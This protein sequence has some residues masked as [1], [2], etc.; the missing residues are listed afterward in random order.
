MLSECIASDLTTVNYT[1][2]YLQFHVKYEEQCGTVGK[3]SLQISFSV[4][5]NRLQPSVSLQNL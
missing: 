5:R 1:N 4:K 2:F 3:L